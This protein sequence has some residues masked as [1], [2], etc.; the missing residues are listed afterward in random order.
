MRVRHETRRRHRAAFTL[1]EMLV[2]VAII[3]AL[4]GIGGFFLMGTLGTA[5]KDTARAQAK[6]LENAAKQYYIRHNQYPAT[7][8]DLLQADVKGPPILEDADALKDPWGNIYQYDPAGS[9]HNGMRPDIWAVAP[10]G[11]KVGN[12]TQ[13]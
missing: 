3:V 7:L 8:Q 1:L 10:D 13:Q 12:W 11:T 4:A 2:V 9:M 6:T 5:Q